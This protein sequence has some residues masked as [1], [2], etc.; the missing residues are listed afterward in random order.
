MRRAICFLV[1]HALASILLL[2]SMA[3]AQ[4]NSTNDG[5]LK[6]LLDSANKMFRSTPA[7]ALVL[8]DEITKRSLETNNLSVYARS[9]IT[10]ATIAYYKG[11]HDEASGYLHN[12]LKTAEQINDHYNIS[13]ACNELGTLYKKHKDREEALRYYTRA[14]EEA[15]QIEDESMISNVF[16]NLGLIY[17]EYQEYEKAL[18]YFQQSLALSKKL[19]SELGEGYSL[20]YIG[21]LKRLMKKFD[22]GEKYL[23]ESLNIRRKLNDDFAAAVNLIY[24]TNLFKDKRDYNK[25]L[26]YALEANS[27]SKAINYP[28]MQRISYQLLSELNERSGNIPAAYSYH[29]EYTAFQDSI[30]NA[31]KNKQIYELKTEYETEKKEQ[32]IAL[33]SQENTIQQLNL[34]QRN[35]YLLFAGLSLFLLLLAGFSFYK[36]RKQREERL[37]QE[38]ELKE[39]L[40]KAQAQNELHQDRLRISRELHDNIGSHLTFI[41]SAVSHLSADTLPR[42]DKIKQVQDLT[43]TTIRELRKT[44]WLINK[45]AI[46][47]EEFSMKLREYFKDQFPL[48]VLFQARTAMELT[49][50]VAT[51]LFRVVQEAVSNVIKH[52]QAERIVVTIS[53]LNDHKLQIEITDNG[54]GFDLNESKT[55]YGIDNMKAR[56]ESINGTFTI[57]SKPNVGTTLT[58]QLPY[59]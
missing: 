54:I 55:G 44:V 20:A 25:A 26:A 15:K 24:L 13:L 27:F 8:L 47:A 51:E 31:Q 28:D 29:K 4:S 43:A 33:L 32:Q 10:R 40:V 56:L 3:Y 53:D 50:T 6:V 30:F 23:L 5:E 14:M 7:H 57:M 39:A 37:M 49:A 59:A 52:A 46:D 21:N 48:Q 19:G 36:N 34:R 11:N 16:N 1:G 9:E 2:H 45:P 17:E 22:E 41:N 38:A 35:V 12:A 42:V 18:D 58:L